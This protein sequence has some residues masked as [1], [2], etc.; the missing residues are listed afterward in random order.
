[1]LAAQVEGD[2][3]KT[4]SAAFSQAINSEIYQLATCW[5]FTRKDGTILGFTDADFPLE[6]EGVTYWPQSG[7]LAS[8]IDRDLS[9]Q[10]NQISL[11]SFFSDQITEADLIQG[12]LD[13]GRVFVFRVDPRNLPAD[14]SSDPLSFEPGVDGEIG[15]IT[16]TDQG[17]VIEVR[18]LE[19]RLSGNNGWVTQATCRNQF[20]DSLCG[21]NIASFTLTV[22]VNSAIDIYAFTGSFSQPYNNYFL[23]GELTWLTGANAGESSTVIYSNGQNIRTLNRFSNPISAGDTASVERGCNKTFQ[24]CREVFGNGVNFNGEPGLIGED[25]LSGVVG[26]S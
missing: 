14:L 13:Y 5:R 16:L 12:R 8:D 17:F 9:L 3:A 18:G 10:S 19:E 6:I 15:Q 26:E 2:M 23:G 1:M 21:L 20:C 22:T 11:K 7:F 24:T 4:Y 25:A